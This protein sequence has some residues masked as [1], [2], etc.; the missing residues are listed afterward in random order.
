MK[1]GDDMKKI[2]TITL[3][4]ILIF[5]NT[6]AYS[7]EF[8][9]VK[10]TKY[11]EAIQFLASYDIA[12]G[13]PDGTFRPDE[14]ITRGEM[15][16]LLTIML[17]Y[18]EYSQNMTSVF[19]DMKGHW[20]EQYVEIMS[21]FD[22]VQGYLD[23]SFRP[24]SKIAYTEAVTMILRTLGYTDKSL[25]GDWP[26]DYYVKAGELGVVDGVPL[27]YGYATRGD[28]ALMLFNVINCNTV[29]VNINEEIEVKKTT[30]LNEIKG[31]KRTQRIT[32]N[33]L[34]NPSKVNLEKYLFHKAD[35]YYNSAGEIV[36]VS[37]IK[38]KEFTGTISSKVSIYKV[39]I[40]DDSG[41]IKLFNTK[42]VPIYYN[43]AEVEKSSSLLNGKVTI[44]YNEKAKTGSAE[45]II[46]V[47]VT[48]VKDVEPIN[49]YE[50]DSHV[51]M[52]KYL[53]IN[54]DNKPDYDN[55]TVT[56]AADSLQTIKEKDVLY[57]YETDEYNSSKTKLAIEAVRNQIAGKIER[58]DYSQEQKKYI[59]NGE[60]YELSPYFV[61]TEKIKLGYDVEVILDKEGKIVKF[62]V[63][64]YH[65]IPQKYGLVIG[66]DSGKRLETKPVELTLPRVKIIDEDGNINI[67][68]VE[69]DS[70]IITK[71]EEGLGLKLSINLEDNDI[72]KFQVEENGKIKSIEE[73]ETEDIQGTYDNSSGL[74][75]KENKI[76]N[77]KTLIFYKDKDN[78]YSLL[79]AKQLDEFILGKIIA[80]Q[81]NE[82]NIMYL[83]KGLKDPY[84]G[85][86][87]GIIKEVIDKLDAKDNEVEEAVFYI[88]KSRS[89]IPNMEKSLKD[90]INK[91]VKLSLKQGK[92][93]DIEV[94]MAE[95]EI[96]QVQEIYPK[97]LQIDG[98]YYEICENAVVYLCTTDEDGKINSTA[99][100]TI[101]DIEVGSKVQFYDTTGEYDGLIDIILVYE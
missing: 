74:I 32:L 44:I 81:K 97:Q 65:Y 6:L 79:E 91:L 92:I 82:I 50:P 40:K 21:T 20:A 9:D 80:N 101:Y 76:I 56:G 24:D 36:Y 43:G 77:D 33:L 11:E 64:D 66:T 93:A 29:K 30:L 48:D 16:K 62:F 99:K 49:I 72:V 41:N 25:P 2:I 35:V 45:G 19:S 13:F 47:E 3:V 75:K 5:T 26:Y 52:G 4:L 42:N 70:N 37:N 39:F 12:D 28:V 95:N 68:D 86:E 15:S 60:T 89:T 1:I 18:K 53:P 58:I 96:T 59:I 34:D 67:Y 14:F 87:Y 7:I 85:Y 61:E 100:G 8:S 22:I 57:F 51:F 69:E 17:G 31:T 38:T 94:V 90:Y 54:N 88:Q 84:T 63:T 46:K 78:E 27:T 73:V 71:S 55:I 98:T 23:G 83:E 10:D